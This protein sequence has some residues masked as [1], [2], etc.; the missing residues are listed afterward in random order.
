M[1]CECVLGSRGCVNEFIASV[2]SKGGTVEQTAIYFPFNGKIP[3]G[4]GHSEVC[5]AL[6]RVLHTPGHLPKLP[7]DLDMPFRT[8]CRS[9]IS[10]FLFT[11]RSQSDRRRRSSSLFSST[12]VLN[13]TT[14]SPSAIAM[15]FRMCASCEV[16][17]TQKSRW[18]FTSQNCKL[19]Q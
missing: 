1:P 6:L 3:D 2:V 12:T 13:D 19:T 15:L 17:R 14:T 8:R 7:P 4:E 11:T 10:V 16:S 5:E 9:A 18:C